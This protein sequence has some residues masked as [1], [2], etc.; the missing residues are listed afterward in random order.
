M[1]MGAT[2]SANKYE[3]LDDSICDSE[4]ELLEKLHEYEGLTLEECIA[5]R[6]PNRKF[7]IKCFK[8]ANEIESKPF[9]RKDE[10]TFNSSLHTPIQQQIIVKRR[11]K[12][13]FIRYCDVIDDL[14]L[15]NNTTNVVELAYYVKISSD[16][17]YD[18]HPHITKTEFKTI[19]ISSDA[20]YDEFCKEP[21]EPCSICKEKTYMQLTESGKITHL[22]TCKLQASFYVPTRRGC[23]DSDNRVTVKEDMFEYFCGECLKKKTLKAVIKDFQNSF[24]IIGHQQARHEAR[25]QL[26]RYITV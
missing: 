17:Y 18:T 24:S 16:R 13:E 9:C 1:L 26:K 15:H 6:F 11:P 21:N 25:L 2:I 22:V 4:I 3:L 14:I 23:Y 5:K 7:E 20:S 10:I 8:S 19:I 12:Q